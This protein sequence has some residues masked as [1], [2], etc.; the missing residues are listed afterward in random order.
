MHVSSRATKGMQPAYPEDEQVLVR[1][2]SR[3]PVTKFWSGCDRDDFICGGRVIA[4]L[5]L[6]MHSCPH[7]P[8]DFLDG[9]CHE[10][11]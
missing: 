10:I 9:S 7:V 2:A 4:T 3:G 5:V 11:K 6:S 8:P 1:S